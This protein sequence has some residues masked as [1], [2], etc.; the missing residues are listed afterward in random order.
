MYWRG[1]P[2]KQRRE[3]IR[4]L[5]RRYVLIGAPEES[6]AAKSTR[7]PTYH[8]QAVKL[9]ES[10]APATGYLLLFKYPRP[11]HF[12]S[13]PREYKNRAG[14]TL[15][16]QVPA[17]NIPNCYFV[18]KQIPENERDLPCEDAQRRRGRTDRGR[19]IPSAGETA[20]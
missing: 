1:P 7:L 3:S 4:R 19:R 6:S 9:C 17:I 18:R 13:P 5:K 16:Y 2:L 12:F 10:A 20:T 14:R 8:L 15:R 11:A